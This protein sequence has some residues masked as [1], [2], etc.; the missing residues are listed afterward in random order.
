MAKCL[1]FENYS[2]LST[3]R[4]T[5]SNCELI[6]CQNHLNLTLIL[7]LILNLNLTLNSSCVK[8]HLIPVA[9]SR[10][11]PRWLY[12]ILTLTIA[13]TRGLILDD[14]LPVSPS[15]KIS[16][17]TVLQVVTKNTSVFSV[18]PILISD[19][20][21]RHVGCH[22]N[23]RR[24][25]SNHTAISDVLNQQCVINNLSVAAIRLL[26]WRPFCTLSGSRQP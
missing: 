10:N 23:Y 11:S 6:T 14:A 5:L 3:I 19:I 9:I 1:L 24:W 26:A 16:S 21:Y 8:C 2:E 18:R 13:L 25:S 20:G 12:T 22:L 4:A 17:V 15:A 7:M